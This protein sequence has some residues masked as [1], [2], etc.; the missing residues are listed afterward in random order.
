VQIQ[1]EIQLYAEGNAGLL[2][3]PILSIVGS[4]NPT[5]YAISCTERIATRC[6]AEGYTLLTD[7]QNGTNRIAADHALAANTPLIA[8]L[9][10]PVTTKPPADLADILNLVVHSGLLVSAVRTPSTVAEKLALKLQSQLVDALVI[11]DGEL[12]GAA[13]NLAQAAAA[14]QKP[15]AA[16]AHPRPSNTTM[17]ARELISSGV[18]TPLANT[19][20]LLSFLSRIPTAAM[21]QAA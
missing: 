18:A 8:L 19:D 9:Q 1:Q 6:I 3:L 16:L 20:D 10:T 11:I 4:N 13:Y 14:L 17:A 5:Q 2:T 21:P 7:L 12:D 15:V